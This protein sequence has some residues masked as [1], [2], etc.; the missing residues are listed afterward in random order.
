MVYEQFIVRRHHKV[1]LSIDEEPAPLYLVMT[2]PIPPL[3]LTCRALHDEIV[4][5]LKP[6]IDSAAVPRII[7]Y[8]HDYKEPGSQCFAL[9]YIVV[10]M[11]LYRSKTDAIADDMRE[12]HKL[13]GRLATQYAI[14]FR[15]SEVEAMAH[16]SS[17]ANRYLRRDHRM[18][19][20]PHQ[21]QIATRGC[22]IGSKKWRYINK[23]L[24]V[25]CR[26]YR[27]PMTRYMVEG[28]ETEECR[29]EDFEYL[30]LGGTIDKQTWEIE[31]A[32]S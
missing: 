2:E 5:F 6:K 13:I 28:M 8:T 22:K 26:T 29:G 3:H 20:S 12:G 23:A 1:K 10:D 15:K 25:A 27:C 17:K 30:R 9:W 11:C 24:D 32:E 31:W 4:P 7:A 18:A 14:E 21:L 16:F 19:D